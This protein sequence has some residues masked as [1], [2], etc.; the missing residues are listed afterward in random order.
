M[1]ENGRKETGMGEV[2]R[3]VREF[4]PLHGSGPFFDTHAFTLLLSSK[5]SQTMSICSVRFFFREF[6]L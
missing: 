6:S 1:R 3:L 4:G 2:Q 5:D